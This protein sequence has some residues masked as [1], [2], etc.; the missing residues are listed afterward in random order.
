MGADPAE[1][2]LRIPNE[3]M[4]Q[5]RL[6]VVDE[7]LSNDMIEHMAVLPGYEGLDGF[8]RFVSAFR[9]AFP[10]LHYD[11]QFHA[12]AGDIVTTVAKGTGTMQG[13]FMGMPAS[14]KRAEWTEI[15][16][17][18]VHDGKVVEH[19]GLVDQLTMMQQLGFI[20]APAGA[21]TG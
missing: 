2:E 3:I 8:K 18:R 14:G 5:G 15:H 13:S 12:S 17:S 7:V 20:P 9:E 21:P 6:D 16:V 1:V 10:D 4:N 19:W 11:V